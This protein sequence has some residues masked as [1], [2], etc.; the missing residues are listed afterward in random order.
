[1]KCPVCGS[2]M[3]RTKK[4]WICESEEHQDPIIIPIEAQN[5]LPDYLKDLPTPVSIP[6][7]E[8]WSETNPY[9]KLYRLCDAAEMITRFFAVVLLSDL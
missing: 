5:P 3:D 8:Y 1:M 2:E 9:I 7:V 4:N 6:L